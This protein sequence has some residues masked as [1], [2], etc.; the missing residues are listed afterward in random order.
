MIFAGKIQKKKAVSLLF[1]FN[2]KNKNKNSNRT[3]QEKLAKWKRVFFLLFFDQLIL[4]KKKREKSK[5]KGQKSI[6]K[7]QPKS[8][9]PVICTLENSQIGNWNLLD[10]QSVVVNRS[11]NN[12]SWQLQRQYVRSNRADDDLHIKR[13]N[14]VWAMKNKQFP[15]GRWQLTIGKAQKPNKKGMPKPC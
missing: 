12:R 4:V 7:R 13:E 8:Y 2:Y 9:A 5:G 10:L 11:Y 3:V 15:I 1:Y 14:H 6:D